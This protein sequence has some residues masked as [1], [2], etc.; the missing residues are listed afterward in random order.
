MECFPNPDFLYMVDFC[1]SYVFLVCVCKIRAA[2]CRKIAK[3]AT[4]AKCFLAVSWQHLG[5]VLWWHWWRFSQNSEA[6][7]LYFC[8]VGAYG[9]PFGWRRHCLFEA[10]SPTDWLRI[11]HGGWQR[12]KMGKALIGAPSGSSFIFCFLCFDGINNA[13][14]LHSMHLPTGRFDMLHLCVGLWLL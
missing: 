5:G 4:S 10:N 2:I 3:T 1:C 13:R 14:I 9:Q 8:A 11:G 6:R 12:G 7:R